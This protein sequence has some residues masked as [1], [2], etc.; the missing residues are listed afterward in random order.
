[1]VVLV[2]PRTWGSQLCRIMVVVTSRGVIALHGVVIRGGSSCS[3]GGRRALCTII[4]R[5]WGIIV[6]HGWGIVVRG[7]G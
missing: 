6:V 2:S 1:M 4:I 7:W 5:G 3:L